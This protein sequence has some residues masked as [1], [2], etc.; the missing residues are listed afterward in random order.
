V[1]IEAE[2]AS[3]KTRIPRL[4]RLRSSP[5]PNA[6]IGSNTDSIITTSYLRARTSQGV[7]RVGASKIRRDLWRLFLPHWLAF[8]TQYLQTFRH[9]VT[10][11]A[12][13]V[14]SQKRRQNPR[15]GNRQI[16]Q[17]GS[18]NWL[19]SS[20]LGIPLACLCNH[21]RTVATSDRRHFRLT[22]MKGM[23]F[24]RTRL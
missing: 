5:S 6:W 24:R 19:V 16:S 20:V 2:P 18:V 13:Q 1:L 17:F 14:K 15:N 7:E 22:L 3:C 9:L 11:W 4:S 23:A 12:S 21:S 10:Q 8:L